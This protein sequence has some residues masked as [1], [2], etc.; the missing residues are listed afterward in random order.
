M[1][2]FFAWSQLALILT[3]SIGMMAYVFA[4]YAA[5]LFDFGERTSA[6]VAAS[7][8]I[9][10]T[11]L[12][13][14]SVTLGKT[15]QNVLTALK[16]VGLGAI[17]VAG[18]GRGAVEPIVSTTAA[19][20]TSGSLGLAMILVLY[21][22]G[23]W[24]DAAFVAAEVRDKKRDIARALLLGTGLITLIYLLVNA[25]FLAGL[26]FEGVRSSRAVAADL[27][28]ASFGEP[29]RAF[30]S[31]LV[32]ISALGA[33]NALI[34]MGARLHSSLGRD[35]AG[36]AA[37]GRWRER[38]QSPF[39]ALTVQA[40]VSVLLIGL[41]G[42]GLGRSLVDRAFSAIGIA[43]TPWSGHGGFDTLLRC[44]A[45]VFWFFFLMTGVSLFV[46][47]VRDR[48]TQRPFRV[49]VFPLTPFVFC[50]TSAWMLFSSVEYAGRLVLLSVPFLLLGIPFYFTRRR[51]RLVALSTRATAPHPALT[52]RRGS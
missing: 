24:N 8:V 7:A 15:A 9:V 40:I 48:S 46:L 21:T 3:A 18:F 36:L 10:L 38:T 4:D 20:S 6:L 51:P 50:A 45:P 32:M 27:L 1:G 28:G 2:F 17:V 12:N 14:A 43:E 35:Y 19:R 33:A 47:R 25:A 23:G 37:L 49:P 31:V 22:F 52:R 16:I 34:F 26:G 39:W 13:V 29:G 11:S 41:A 5:A 44:S 30:I 42:L